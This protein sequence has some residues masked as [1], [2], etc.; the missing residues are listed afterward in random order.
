MLNKILEMLEISVL[1]LALGISF[2][3]S[4]LFFYRSVSEWIS[5]KF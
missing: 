5:K 4:G 2:Y 1:V 3:N